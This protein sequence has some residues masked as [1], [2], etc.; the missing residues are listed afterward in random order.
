MMIALFILAPFAWYA[1]GVSGFIF[2]WRTDHKL[3][4]EAVALAVIAGTVGPLAWPVGYL[5]HRKL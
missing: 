3:T 1:S 4:K 2:W 5:I